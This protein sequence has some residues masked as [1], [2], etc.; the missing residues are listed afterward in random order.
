MNELVIP[1][2]LRAIEVNHAALL[3]WAN[4]MA[5]DDAEELKSAVG[6]VVY[7]MKVVPSWRVWFV[8]LLSPGDFHTYSGNVHQ[9]QHALEVANA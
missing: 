9:L 5:K 2:D 7:G 8:L 4:L 6:G 1:T 3:K